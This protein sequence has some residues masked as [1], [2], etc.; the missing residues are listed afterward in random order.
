MPKGLY[1]KYK[2]GYLEHDML[3]LQLVYGSIEE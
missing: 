2:F 3:E 1:D